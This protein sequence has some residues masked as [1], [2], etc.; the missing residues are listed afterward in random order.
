MSMMQE[1]LDKADFAIRSEHKGR[2]SMTRNAWWL[3]RLEIL[4]LQYSH[5]DLLEE[6]QDL[7][8]KLN[9]SREMGKAACEIADRAVDAALDAIDHRDGLLS[10]CEKWNEMWWDLKAAKDQADR[11]LAAILAPKPP[12][13]VKR[14]ARSVIE[15][16]AVL[17]I[18]LAILSA[19]WGLTDYFLNPNTAIKLWP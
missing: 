9:E 8:K 12:T 1:F 17:C 2:M 11:E 3:L 18:W 4:A 6:N 10:M 5:Q 19:T 15:C 13:A 16:I 7:S 14:I